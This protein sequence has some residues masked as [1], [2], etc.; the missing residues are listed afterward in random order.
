MPEVPGRPD[1][2][3]LYFGKDDAESDVSGAGL[4]RA[5]FMRTAAYN[6]V[7]QGRKQLLIGRKGAGKSAICMMLADDAAKHA[8]IVTPDEISAD[9]IRQFELQGLTRQMSKQLIWRYVLAVQI[10]K[11]VLHHARTAHG[12]TPAAVCQL[13]K[14]LLENGELND[15][16]RWHERFWKTI[17]QLRSSLSL[18][19]FGI[20]ANLELGKGSAPS[21]GI[22]VSQQLDVVEDWLDR[23]IHDLDCPAGHGPLLVL[24]DQIEKVWS[25]DVNSDDMVVGLLTASK[26]VSSRFRNVRCVVCIRSDIYDALQFPERDKF[27]GDEMRIEWSAAALADMLM[28][29]AEAAVGSTGANI[30]LFGDYFVK[31]VDERPTATYLIERTLMRPRDLIQFANLCRDTTAKN[32]RKYVT[33]QD[34]VEAERQYSVWKVQDLANEY[35]INYPFLADLFV[36]FQNSGYVVDRDAFDQLLST[37]ASTLRSRHPRF[38]EV[39]TPHGVTSVLYGI[40][41][42][43]VRRGDAFEYVHDNNLPLD[44]TEHQFCVHPCFRQALHTVTATGVAAYRPLS[45]RSSYA[46]GHTP[47]SWLGPR[48]VFMRGDEPFLLYDAVDEAGERAARVF[49]D[50]PVAPEFRAELLGSVSAM[51]A[52]TRERRRASRSVESAIEQT[53]W[54]SQFFVRLANDLASIHKLTGIADRIG[55]IGLGLD[56]LALGLPRYDPR[57]SELS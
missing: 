5:G 53:R 7:M 42:L 24:V 32:G 11:L 45:T 39:F 20:K 10:A 17:Q 47:S 26:H 41:F 14:F 46:L 16:P 34:I 33:A 48:E 30:R 3:L 51:L 49:R 25:N 29:R 23:A 37:L 27:R 55:R 1:F 31:T 57:P 35:L 9:E 36:L 50:A 52:D 21:E 18:E 8:S 44:G 28:V 6:M 54:V 43:G 22:R 40:G 12:K 15:D 19:A 38:A 4:L 56:E 13:R 2:D